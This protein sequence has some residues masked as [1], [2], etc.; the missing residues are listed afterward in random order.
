MKR[1]LLPHVESGSVPG[2]VALV[3]HE[4][5][6]HVEALGSTAYGTGGAR[7][8]GI[9]RISSMS[10]PVTAAAAMTLVDDGK[11]RLEDLVDRYLPELSDRRVLKRADGP[12][13]ETVPTKRA[14]TVRDLL[15][16]TMGIGMVFAPPGALP[17][18]RA[19]DDLRLGQG[20]PAPSVPPEPDEWI[21]RVGTLPLLHQPGEQ[22]MYNTG[23][24]VLGV[25][26]RRVAGMP[27]GVF[28]KRR[29]FEPLGMNDTDFY[30]PRSKIDRFVDSYWT[31]PSTGKTELYDPAS[32]GQ[33]SRPPE[34][35]SGAAGL[36]STADDFL[37]FAT[38]MMEK[39]SARG[40]RVLS[41]DS[42][43]VMT[44]DQ[45]TPEQ[46]R[47][48]VFAPGFFDER[49]W[50]FCMSVVT[51]RDPVKSRGTYGWDGGMGTSWF[52]DPARG[53]TAIL[54]T[55]QMQKSPEPPPVYLDFW[56]AAYSGLG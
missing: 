51:G 13:D 7:K 10:K 40:K 6:T 42:V 39:G 9:F 35:P 50:G 53:L 21:R 43:D 1:A 16:F 11:L 54:M 52:N 14:M 5:D 23:A 15:M 34:F 46:K 47:G 55:Q 22:W 26:I 45:L 41:E 19:M 31:N 3:S 8:D 18:Q 33:W 29:I 37:A 25:L 12:L 2:L 48:S 56:K 27:F 32:T 24:D 20:V 44:A 4:G 17:I 28:L 36:V 49:G 30:V 38:M